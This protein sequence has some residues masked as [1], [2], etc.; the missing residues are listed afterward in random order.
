MI[1]YYWYLFLAK[2]PW[3]RRRT[4][5]QNLGDYKALWECSASALDAIEKFPESP[6]IARGY[7]YRGLYG[8]P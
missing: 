3:V 5:L 4:Y 1:S 6:E 8:T 2:L 7:L